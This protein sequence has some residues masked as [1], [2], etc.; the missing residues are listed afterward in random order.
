MPFPCSDD[1]FRE[2]Q[3]AGWTVG[4]TAACGTGGLTWIVTGTNGENV[5]EARGKSQS[6]AWWQAR[7][8]ARLLGMLRGG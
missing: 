3:R 7:E 1:S 5:I 6:E 4:D 8:Q 2:L